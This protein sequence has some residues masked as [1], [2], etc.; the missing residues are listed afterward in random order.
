MHELWALLSP[1][2]TPEQLREFAERMQR[3]EKEDAAQL[4]IDAAEAARLA[5]LPKLRIGEPD[6]PLAPAPIFMAPE[7]ANEPVSAPPAPKRRGRSTGR[8]V[9][10]T[11]ITPADD[12]DLGALVDAWIPKPG[13]KKK[14]INQIIVDFKQKYD[15]DIGYTTVRKYVDNRRPELKRSE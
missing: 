10:T 15:R 7:S 4:V 5:A 9:G 11:H 2:K 13:T 14:L 8:P 12:A 6:E 1:S 3:L